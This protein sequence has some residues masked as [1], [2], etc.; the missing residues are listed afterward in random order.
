MRSLNNKTEPRELLDW[1]SDNRLTPENLEYGKASFPAEAVRR[2]LL[3]QQYYLCAYTLI[4]LK[5]PEECDTNNQTRESCHIEHILPQTRGKLI[6]EQRNGDEVREVIKFT[7]G[8][9]IDFHNMVACYP[10]SISKI[11]CGYGAHY[12]GDYDPYDHP[13]FLSPLM[14]NIESH[15]TFS[16]KGHIESSTKKG[17]ETIRALQ[18]DHTELCCWRKEVINGAIYPKGTHRDPISAAD[19]R[20][21]ADN[22]LQPSADGRLRE[23]CVAIHQVALKHADK[24]ER[25]ASRIAA[26]RRK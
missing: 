19:A 11:H 5:K 12:K 16:D 10:P 7:A 20:R 21:L 2:A 24:L 15:F 17:Q 13:D 25:R 3:A 1:K 8:E 6:K 26:Q 14:P 23:F 9:D 4:R 18:L 22:V